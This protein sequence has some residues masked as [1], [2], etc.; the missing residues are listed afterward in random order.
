MAKHTAETY[1][2][3]E[4]LALWRQADADV[5]AG[6]QSKAIR[7]RTLTQANAAEISNKIKFYESRIAAASA[8]TRPSHTQIEFRT[9]RR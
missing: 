5:A 6:G 9:N 3:A 8:R 1:T 2:D 4:L 7:G